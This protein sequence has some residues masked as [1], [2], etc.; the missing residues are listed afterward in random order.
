MSDRLSRVAYL[1]H[2]FESVAIGSHLL[3]L[4]TCNSSLAVIHEFDPW[5]NFRAAQYLHDNGWKAFV[6]WFDHKVWYP[7]GRPGKCV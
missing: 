1:L 2:E 5:F 6:N 4:S 7:L 3:Y